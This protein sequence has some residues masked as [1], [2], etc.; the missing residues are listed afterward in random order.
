MTTPNRPP[1]WQEIDRAW[2]SLVNTAEPHCCPPA[3][4]QAACVIH[5]LRDRLAT[6]MLSLATCSCC[7]V[8]R[9]KVT[10][11]LTTEADRADRGEL[12]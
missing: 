8:M 2:W 1:L 10:D 12:L 4:N 3:S 5:A 9:D 7:D 11:W 6:E